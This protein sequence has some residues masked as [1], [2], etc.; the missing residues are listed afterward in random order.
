MSAGATGSSTYALLTDGS[1]VEIRPAAPGDAEAVREMHAAMS[2]DNIY[3][4]FFSLSPRSADRRPSALPGAGP[5]HGALLAWLGDRLAGV[6]SYEPD[7]AAGPAE[8]A[9]AVPD[10]LHGRGVATLLLEHLVSLARLRGLTRS[11]RHP[12]GQR[13][14]AARVRRRRAAGAGGSTASSS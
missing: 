12:A 1:T 2:P 10:D 3:L 9:F 11:A 14:D 13:R 4:R 7:C 5:D 6:A 8:I